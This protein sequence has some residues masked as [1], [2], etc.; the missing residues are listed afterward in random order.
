MKR[1]L[2]IAILVLI[3][4]D[5][6]SAQV[7]NYVIDPTFDTDELYTKGRITGLLYREEFDDIY[8]SFR[9]SS[10]ISEA[11]DQS[12]VD[13]NGNLLYNVIDVH[14]STPHPFREG[15][16]S[17]AGGITYRI[18]PPHPNEG[19]YGSVE[20]IFSFEYGKNLYSF[21]GHTNIYRRILIL[22]DT[23]V[24]MAGRYATDSINPGVEG[25]RHLIRIDS[26]GDPVEEFPEIICEP[27]SS[28]ANDIKP[29]SEGKFWLAGEFSVINGHHTN[30]LA[31]LNADFTIDTTYVS[32]FLESHGWAS[33]INIDSGGNIWTY[34]AVGCDIPT[35]EL[36]DRTLM[37]LTPE[38]IIDENFNIPDAYT[39]FDSQSDELF[40]LAPSI[41]F[42]DTDGNFI[43]G[44]SI[45]LYNGVPVKRFFKITPNGDLIPDAFGDLG[46]DE[47][48]WDGWT[49][50][51]EYAHVT[52][53]NIQRLPD[54][55]LLVGGAFSSFGGEPY[56]CLV[57]L[58]QDGFVSTENQE[59]D[60]FG[61]H[62][63][64]NPANTFVKWNKEVES[65]ALVNALGQTVLE[66]N[67]DG[68]LRQMKLPLL[69]QGLYT[70]VFHKDNQ[71][72][73]KKLL[74]QQR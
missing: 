47:A 60:D 30:Y 2:I 35:T 6:L 56:S 59:G 74:I 7:N 70:L 58:E 49:F 23:T 20:E 1:P 9:R 18:L 40:R 39:F 50:D 3:C 37:K 43:M 48:V 12:I 36:E 21:P 25:Y 24:L 38:G 32:P 11:H 68:R 28:I 33:I 16:L 54:G 46:A 17:G 41:A 51:P 72:T 31:R 64:P 34:C 14:G 52:V 67:T 45:M 26:I 62:V 69:P 5:Y 44:N 55:K 61:I 13:Y 42:E 22:E 15:I 65:V 10:D 63:W 8:V 53:N 29:A 66:K 71:S 19:G 4:V 57:R 27:W 73:S